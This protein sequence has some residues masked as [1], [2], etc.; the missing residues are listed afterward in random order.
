MRLLRIEEWFSLYLLAKRSGVEAALLQLQEFIK[1]LDC[2][3][4]EDAFELEKSKAAIHDVVATLNKIAL[5][6]AKAFSGNDSLPT[7]TSVINNA[8]GPGA[9]SSTSVSTPLSFIPDSLSR[10]DSVSPTIID[11]QEVTPDSTRGKEHFVTSLTTNVDLCSSIKENP[12]LNLNFP[13]EDELIEMNLSISY[14]DASPLPSPAEASDVPC[15]EEPFVPL[16]P[17]RFLEWESSKEDGCMWWIKN[18]NNAPISLDMW[19]AWGT[20]STAEVLQCRKQAFQ[21]TSLCD[22]PPVYV[23]QWPMTIFG[24]PKYKCKVAI[25]AKIRGKL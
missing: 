20:I 8:S 21:D 11:L 5:D 13:T 15:L 25:G 17:P 7:T 16:F 9:S 10:T 19:Q 23:S 6:T 3:E 14:V 22:K 18:I 24:T 2:I 12:L 1:I 4:G